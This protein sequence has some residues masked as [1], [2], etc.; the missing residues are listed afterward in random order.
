MSTLWLFV[1]LA[2]VGVS[3]VGVQRLRRWRNGPWQTSLKVGGSVVLRCAGEVIRLRLEASPQGLSLN[4][5]HRKPEKWMTEKFSVSLAPEEGGGEM[6]FFPPD[7]WPVD[8][9]KCIGLVKI[10][11]QEVEVRFEKRGE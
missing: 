5:S 2:L 10:S 7:D 1:L 6:Q 11:D 9:T 8:R 4:G 3:V